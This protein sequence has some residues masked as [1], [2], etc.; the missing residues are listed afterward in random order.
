[1]PI[2]VVSG[3]Q[4]ASCAASRD[5]SPVA[6]A[7]FFLKGYKGS[8]KQAYAED[9]R[10]FFV[11]CAMLDVAVFDV[12]RHVVQDFVEQLRH[13]GNGAAT[14]K[15]K[16]SVIRNFYRFAV[17]EEY[18][19]RSPV[20]ST[21]KPLHLASVS[22]RSQTLG[23]DR[24]ESVALLDAARRRGVLD[25]AVVRT[26]L[27]QGL[28][29]SELC[30]LDVADMRVERGHRVFR[31][32]RK[33]DVVQ[34]Q[35]V[36]PAAVAAIDVFLAGRCEGPLFVDAA[37]DRLTRYQVEYV[38]R[39]CAKAAGVVKRLSPHSFRHACVTL[40]L[41]AEVGVPDV[42]EFMG[43]ANVETTM[44][45]DLGRRVLDGSPAYALGL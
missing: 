45:Y 9:L 37:G 35:V 36:A 12:R 10:Q 27:H 40:L 13:D 3:H 4:I 16:I 14:I 21:D 34:D 30:G 7:E 42:R 11:F 28:R 33:G 20:P 38:V 6:V 24:D 17:D 19:E 44:R 22:R 31:L 8:T 1:M 18:A 2:T 41:D 43:H 39:E 23:P 25:Y 26:L 5:P 32:S 29:V 15:R